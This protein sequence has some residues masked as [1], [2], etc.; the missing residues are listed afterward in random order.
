MEVVNIHSYL[1]VFVVVGVG[2][3]RE[4]KSGLYDEVDDLVK[5]KILIMQT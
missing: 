3:G 5:K 2:V 1:A 4:M